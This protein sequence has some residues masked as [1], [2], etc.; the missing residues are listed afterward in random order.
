M[1]AVAGRPWTPGSSGTTCTRPPLSA[2]WRQPPRQWSWAMASKSTR[3]PLG[4]WVVGP[5]PASPKRP[6]KSTPPARPKYKTLSVPTPPTGRAHG[7]PV[8][9]LDDAVAK[10]LSHE[11]TVALPRVAGGR[12]PVW[13]AACVIEDERHIAALAR[14][15]LDRVTDTMP[16]PTSV[17]SPGPEAALH[18]W[19]GTGRNGK[20]ARNRE[21][22]SRQGLLDTGGAT[23]SR[24]PNRR[25][26]SSD[27]NE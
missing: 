3:G 5:F 9:Y 21:P 19:R 24:F 18:P 11:A 20:A 23:G 7:L 10:V 25:G 4:A 12:E 1:P 17:P 22:S 26:L 2:A 15:C 27:G 16:G 13:A 8:S 6:G 14:R